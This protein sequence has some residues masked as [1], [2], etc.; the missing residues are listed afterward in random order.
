MEVEQGYA[1]QGG[2]TANVPVGK[3]SYHVNQP[4]I[5]TYQVQMGQRRLNPYAA[6][7]AAQAANAGYNKPRGFKRTGRGSR[8]GVNGCGVNA[9]PPP[10]P[11]RVHAPATQAEAPAVRATAAA[12]SA[13]ARDVGATLTA[14]HTGSTMLANNGAPKMAQKSQR[15]QQLDAILGMGSGLMGGMGGKGGSGSGSASMMGS[16]G[17]V[18]GSGTSL[19]KR[20]AQ[21]MR[22]CFGSDAASPTTIAAK[23]QRG[24]SGKTQ[25]RVGGRFTSK[26]K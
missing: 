19:G 16:G 7:A 1:A 13:A 3:T 25:P 20:L 24:D 10:P 5:G 6:V 14:P 4:L 11:R 8:F 21:D 22:V 9:P 15:E 26:K 17:G 18:R 12:V 2:A 23:R